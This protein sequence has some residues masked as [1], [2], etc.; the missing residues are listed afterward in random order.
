MTHPALSSKVYQVGD[1]LEAIEMYYEKDWTDGLPVVPPTPAKVQQ[2][3]EY[4]GR[5]PDEILCQVPVRR[6]TVTVEK[7][8]I[9][10]VMAGCL[11]RYMPVIVTAV[12]AMCDDRYNL[13]GSAASTGGSATLLIVNG[14]IVK[15]LE[16]NSGMNLFGPGCR[17]NATIGRALRLVLMNVCGS[18]PGTLDRTTMGHPGKYTYC[19]AEKEDDSPWEPYHVEKGFDPDTSTVTVMPALGPHQ[20]GAQTSNTAESLLTSFASTMVAM[21]GYREGS[22]W[23]LGSC[24]IVIGGE[25]RGVITREGWDKKQVK[26][27]L[28]Q[29]SIRS[30]AELKRWGT[31]P[32]E[33]KPGDD[34]KMLAA[35][36]SADEII[37]LA[38]GGGGTWSVCIAPWAEGRQAGPVTRAIAIGAK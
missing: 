26:E 24:V 1:S 5:R 12:E 22:N 9:N 18:I 33:M 13:H 34:E 3:I 28:Y 14:P 29:R 8:A 27:F 17:A 20:I 35:V 19:I 11:P 31:M 30:A 36:R 4:V 6:R 32:G 10:A 7:V 37:V 21:S 23:G 38:A 16:I 25:H 15:E 2:F